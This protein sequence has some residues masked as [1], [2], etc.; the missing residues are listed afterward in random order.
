MPCAQAQSGDGAVLVITDISAQ[1]VPDC[2][3]GCSVSQQ[4]GNSQRVG[5]M[6]LKV[7]FKLC[8]VLSG[9]WFHWG[10]ISCSLFS[11][12]NWGYPLG[13]E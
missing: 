1:S 12:G 11:V 9:H 4:T 3:Q 10:F 8:T 13:H 6:L 5:N 2:W 7:I